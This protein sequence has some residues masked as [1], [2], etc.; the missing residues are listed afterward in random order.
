[1]NEIETTDRT[2]IDSL[3]AAH[4]ANSPAEH[5]ETL[6]S[7]GE[8]TGDAVVSKPAIKARGVKTLRVIELINSMG[9][10]D[11]GELVKAIMA[12]FNTTKANATAF[13]YNARKRM[14]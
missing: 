4:V 6:E 14:A 8:N 12:E 3:L 2:L 10:A 7:P 1:M 11:K 9:E 13:I 5:V